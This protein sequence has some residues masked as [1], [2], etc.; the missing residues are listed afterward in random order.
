MRVCRWGLAHFRCLDVLSDR[1]LT[2]MLID[3]L[4]LE[5]KRLVCVAVH[6]D[7]TRQNLQTSFEFS[8][9]KSVE[10]DNGE[11]AILKISVHLLLNCL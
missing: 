1:I 8:M 6:K 3:P 9:G 7:R 5:I 11:D 2:Y 10:V 4:D